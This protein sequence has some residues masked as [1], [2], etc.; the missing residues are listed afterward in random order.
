MTLTTLK[1]Y[2]EWQAL[3][4]SGK[5]TGDHVVML[6]RA[7]MAREGE[8]EATVFAKLAMAEALK[9]ANKQ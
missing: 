1:A 9:A 7:V 2:R 3:C 4:A 6:R 8:H 5:A